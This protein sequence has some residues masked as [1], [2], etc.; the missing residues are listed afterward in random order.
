MRINTANE[1]T[2][3]S[4]I[5]DSILMHIA[6][7]MR[8]FLGPDFIEETLNSVA[9]KKTRKKGTFK[10]D[11][12]ESF[13][14]GQSIMRIFRYIRFFDSNDNIVARSLID[15]ELASLTKGFEEALLLW[16][17]RYVDL[18]EG[19]IPFEYSQE[20]IETESTNFLQS[21]VDECISERR[22]AQEKLSELREEIT[23]IQ[24]EWRST[25]T[26]F[27]PRSHSKMRNH[28]KIIEIK[29]SLDGV[30]KASSL[31]TNCPETSIVEYAEESHCIL[32]KTI[33][34][35]F[36]TSSN[37]S[38]RLLAL[39]NPSAENIDDALSKGR[40]LTRLLEINE[41]CKEIFLK[42]MFNI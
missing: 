36:K 3:P 39:E 13:E 9:M 4:F 30:I 27:L 32:V 20:R 6:N 38:T 33:L 37:E 5:C 42:R 1:S 40:A 7:L 28:E 19:E 23:K 2:N 14:I 18:A 8:I 41:K 24:N 29:R 15:E 35:K 22:T 34:I 17:P 25:S 31:V 26:L 16:R 12:I 10:K 11:P 21:V